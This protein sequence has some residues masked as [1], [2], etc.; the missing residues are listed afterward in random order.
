MIGFRYHPVRNNPGA[1]RD[2]CVWSLL[3]LQR[4]SAYAETVSSYAIFRT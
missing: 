3:N 4:I 1:S 2:Y